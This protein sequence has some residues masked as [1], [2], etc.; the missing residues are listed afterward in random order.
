MP[1]EIR[2]NGPI[3]GDPSRINITNIQNGKFRDSSI[4]IGNESSVVLDFHGGQGQDAIALLNLSALPHK[5]MLNTE[6]SKWDLNNFNI[7]QLKGETKGCQIGVTIPV[8]NNKSKSKIPLNFKFS[9]NSF[10]Y[11]LRKAMDS[12]QIVALFDS[13]LDSEK[14]LYIFGILRR[15][16]YRFNAFGLQKKS[17]TQE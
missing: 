12:N 14:E 6:I 3:Q 1:N 15:Q 7:V 9:Q 2:Q 8:G 13:K 16:C 10:Y 17:F 11:D 4:H 5:D